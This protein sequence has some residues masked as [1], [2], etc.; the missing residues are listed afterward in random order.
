MC[1]RRA[2]CEYSSKKPHL[3]MQR[4]RSSY[5]HNRRANTKTFISVFICR[6]YSK[7][8]FN[9]MHALYC[10]GQKRNYLT[11]CL[12][13]LCYPFRLWIWQPEWL[14]PIYVKSRLAGRR[15][16][17]HELCLARLYSPSSAQP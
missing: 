3:I 8:F 1:V 5:F 12:F 17:K 14:P 11:K 4:A 6:F 9:F 7:F 16:S 2:V 10:Y 13:F 15:L